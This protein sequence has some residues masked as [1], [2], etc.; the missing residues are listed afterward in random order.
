MGEL[1]MAGNDWLQMITV[2]PDSY[3]SDYCEEQ[4]LQYTY[5]DANDW[6]LGGF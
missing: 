4:Q 5:P 2:E 1:G 6:L 3:A